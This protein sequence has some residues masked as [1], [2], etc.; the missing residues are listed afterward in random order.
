MLD[1]GGRRLLAGHR[2]GLVG[3]VGSHDSLRRVM[4]VSSRRDRLFEGWLQASP[5]A[6]NVNAAMGGRTRLLAAYRDDGDDGAR[7][8]C[9]VIAALP[10]GVAS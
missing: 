7:G 3:L 10:G 1:A 8:G 6:F 5:L 4:L 9:I 2:R